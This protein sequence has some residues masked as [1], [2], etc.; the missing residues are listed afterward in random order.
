MNRRLTSV[1]LDNRSTRYRVRIESDP[2]DTDLLMRQLQLNLLDN[3]ANTPELT[4]CGP[5]PFQTMKM[6]HDGGAWIVELEA[7]V[8]E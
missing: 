4:A 8:E 5:V 2:C 6:Y 3:M 1:K 7:I